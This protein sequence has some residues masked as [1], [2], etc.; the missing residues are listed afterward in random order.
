MAQRITAAYF[1]QNNAVFA[2][3][4]LL[5]KT[6][7]RR[8]EDGSE[9]RATITETEAYYGSDDL[10]SHASK[11]RTARTEIMFGPGGYVYMYLI[12]GRYWLL[13]IVTGTEGTP[14]AVLIR[15]LS[16]VSG[17][18]R[19]GNLL[20][21]DRSFYGENLAVSERLWIED[22]KLEG[23]VTTGPR[24]GIDY[25]GEEWRLK[26]WRFMLEGK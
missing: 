10:A 24:V 26:A 22:S 15:G 16:T 19:V 2:A 23:R 13:N 5:G 9:V 18:G 11:G 12:Y 7:M 3:R 6:L 1:Q 17:P 21:L 25:A 4:D 20:K 14:E 8:F